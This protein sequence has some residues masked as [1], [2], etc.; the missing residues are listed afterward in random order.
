MKAVEHYR[1]AE[2]ALELASQTENTSVAESWQ[3]D[4]IVHALLACA[5][6]MALA[7][8]ATSSSP[9]LDEWEKAAG[10]GP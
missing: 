7:S 1:E 9:D 4:A 3:R 10:E 6:A 2:K 5:G 8:Y